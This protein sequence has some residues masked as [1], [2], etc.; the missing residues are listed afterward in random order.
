MY[1]VLWL[2]VERSEL[3]GGRNEA[4][5]VRNLRV[6]RARCPDHSS[7]VGA[8]PCILYCVLVM[9]CRWQE[10]S[11]Q[12]RAQIKPHG[13]LQSHR[14]R[15]PSREPEQKHAQ[16]SA[17]IILEATPPTRVCASLGNPPARLLIR[18]LE[19][20]KI[21]HLFPRS[22]WPR[23]GEHGGGPVSQ[24]LM[25]A[26]ERRS[27]VRIPPYLHFLGLVAEVQ[28]EIRDLANRPFGN[29]GR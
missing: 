1:L 11:W 21:T 16:H 26:P 17:R 10:A 7:G 22:T 6:H 27:T 29:R 25:A 4:A 28:N 24:L 23:T 8:L 15:A 19:P 14:D 18:G 5:R 9:G 2:P 13:S 12:G 3:R 20:A